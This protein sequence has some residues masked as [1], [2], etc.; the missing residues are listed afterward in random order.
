MLVN[1]ARS[2]RNYSLKA[3]PTISS[4]SEGPKPDPTPHL[5]QDSSRRFPPK[6]L[7]AL[8]YIKNV[9]AGDKW[10]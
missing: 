5:P 6:V 4:L 9:V 2:P 10:W 7:I 3:P 1:N 8:G